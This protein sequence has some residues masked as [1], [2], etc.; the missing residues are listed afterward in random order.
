MAMPIETGSGS[1]GAA[2]ATTAAGGSNNATGLRGER[3]VVTVLFADVVNSTGL[4]ESLDPEDWTEIMDG[5]FEHLTAP[6]RRYDGTVARLMGD[7]MLAFFGAPVAH[8]ADPQRAV[9]AALD[10][11]DAIRAYGNILRRSRQLD[12]KVRIGINTG[13]VV[14]ADVGSQ[15]A[16]ELTAMGDA[17][18][19]AARMQQTAAPGT[20]Q[21]AAETYRLVSALFEVKP[22]G[23]VEVK[24]KSEPLPTYQVVG[25]KA[26]PDR[27]RGLGVAAPLVGRDEQLGQLKWTIDQLREGRGQIVCLVGEAGL[28]KSRLLAEL[29]EYWLEQNDPFGWD[30]AYGVP[31]DATRPFGLFQNYARGMFGIHLDDTAEVIHQKVEATFRATGGPEEAMA[32]CSVAMER[33]I[34]AKV[35]HEAREYSAEEVKNDIYEI[36]YP[37]FRESCTAGPMICVVDD[38]QWADQASVDLLIRL[39]E[40]TDE[41]PLMMLLAFRPER[42][43]PAWQVKLRAETDYPHRYTEIVLR[44]LDADDTDALV[45]A[46]LH[47][48]DLPAELHEL[49]ARKTDGNPYFVEEVIRS[50]IDQGAIERTDAGLRW[51]EGTAVGDIAIPDSLQALLMARIDR[52]DQET[53]STLQMASVIGRSFYYRILQ[54]ISDSALAVDRHLH[55]LE[56]VELLREAGRMPELEYIFRHELARDAAYATILNRRRREFHLRVAEAIEGLFADRLEEHAHRLA[57]HFE[58]AGDDE[59]AMKYYEMAGR[60]A[61]DIHARAE[62]LTHFSRAMEAAQRAGVPEADMQRLAAARA[63]LE[64]ESA[65]A[66]E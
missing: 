37:A 2:G 56:R 41:V 13:P 58:L 40:L 46:L 8:E 35:L 27:L 36:M 47:I 32:L 10:I 23:E 42:Q 9:L 60:V 20:I 65:P 66:A 44:P 52:L 4:A 15:V 28:G 16:M 54:A 1:Q 38:L 55:A 30:V 57:Q 64:Q 50:L 22:L 63:A 6:I 34:A 17:V 31:Y 14:V 19:I 59:R 7:G 62:G 51:K 25:P 49:I 53:R 21:L 12:F 33:V 26:R 18:N 3:R 43:S 5:A 61:V 39:L 48:P 29:R 11:Q 45:A 24:G